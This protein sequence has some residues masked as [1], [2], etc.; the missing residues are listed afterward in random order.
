MTTFTIERLA[1]DDGTSIAFYRWPVPPEPVR[2]AV[3]IV[4]GIGEYAARYDRFAQALLAAGYAVFASDHRGHGHTVQRPEDLGHLGDSGAFERVLEDVYAVNQHIAALLP[5]VPRVVFGHSFGSFVT[6]RYVSK[7]GN[8]IAAAVLSG[9]DW[10]NSV[11]YLGL[12]VAKLERLRLGASKPSALLQRLIFGEYN[13]AF[14][15]TNSPSAW[16]TRD[17]AEVQKYDDDPLCG[18]AL[19][20]QTWSELL[21]GLISIDKKS[22]LNQ[23]PPHLPIYLLAGDRDP[24]GRSGR[25]PRALAQ[26][27]AKAGLTHVTLKLYPEGRHESL[28]EINRDEVTADVIRWLD[29]NVRHGHSHESSQIPGL[30]EAG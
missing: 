24:V 23:I 12:G 13:R 29:A 16:L 27:Y 5:D 28:N 22:V 9:T 14:R 26:A 20:T 18:F 2:A 7:Y 4:H 6:Q 21:A 10:G 19:T 15:P 3:Q 17:E 11:A 25:G 1:R 30:N 8:S